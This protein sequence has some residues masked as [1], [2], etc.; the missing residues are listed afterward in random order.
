MKFFV[1]VLSIFPLFSNGQLYQHFITF[2]D[3]TKIEA[4]EFGQKAIDFYYL[5]Q[6]DS[7]IYYNRF[8]LNDLRTY[9]EG[10]YNQAV[11]FGMSNNSDSTFYNLKKYIEYGKEKIN[12]GYY[13]NIAFSCLSASQIDSLIIL[14]KDILTN[15]N[16]KVNLELIYNLQYISGKE[17]EILG[18][19]YIDS[20]LRNELLLANFKVFCNLVDTN[21]FPSQKNIE[22]GINNISL[23]ILHADYIP[24]IQNSLGNKL[25]ADFRKGYSKKMAAYIIDRSLRNLNQPQLY[26]TILMTDGS[27]N[28][29]LYKVDDYKKMIKRRK[30]LKFQ[31]I[32]RYLTNFSI[33]K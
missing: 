26:G 15:E 20:K 31:P 19:N 5:N 16:K 24:S 9:Y 27:N 4:Q 25:M 30:K 11:C 14:S 28:R 17:Q 2:Q 13:K 32:E 12:V 6:Y 1:T 7:A 18:N 10:Y 23:I 33:L 21:N 22:N 8:V 3:P 29:V